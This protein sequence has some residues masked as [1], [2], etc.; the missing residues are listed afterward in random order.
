VSK[1]EGSGLGEHPK[2]YG[3]PYL[4]MQP[5]KL[6]TSNLVYNLGLGSSLQRK[7]F[8]PK[9]AGV[10]AREH[11]KIGTPYLFLQSLKL[12]SSNLV[13]NTVYGVR[14]NN[15]FSTEFVMAGWATGAPQKLWVSRTPYHVPC[16]T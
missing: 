8:G 14:Y 13:H 11:Q 15:N 4:F 6:A 16:T 5:L 2:K 7:L 10:R 12:A 3:T 1:L 9:L